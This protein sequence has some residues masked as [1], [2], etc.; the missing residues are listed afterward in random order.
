[1]SKFEAEREKVV[2]RLI[3]EG[4]LMTPSVI[5]SMKI[6]PREEFVPDDMRGYA[7]VDSPLPIGQ[8]QTISA[9]HMCAIMNE[10]LKFEVGHKVLEVGAGSGYH[11]ALVAEIVA[12]SNID[13]KLWGHV[14][15]VE[16]VPALAVSAQKNL[17]K[18]GYLN[19]VSIIN[20]DGSQGYLEE[21]PY[22]RIF[23]T[24]AAPD[25]PKPLIEQLKPGGIMVIPVGG[26]YLY[27]E[28]LLVEK[29]ATGEAVTKSVC[30]VAFVLLRGQYG[31][32]EV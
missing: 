13:S 23:V 17:E 5:R 28:L 1:M 8:G 31:W 2:N 9:P 10:A 14:Y 3:A 24:A 21:A 20:A 29:S 27:Q 25:V 22:D 12:P 7:Y 6:V 18:T 32:K 4:I 11:A 19:R 30:G 26:Q 16:I 15:T